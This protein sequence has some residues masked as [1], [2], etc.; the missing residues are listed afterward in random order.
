[1][2]F[3]V[4]YKVAEQCKRVSQFVNVFPTQMKRCW[5]MGTL[6]YCSVSMF[7]HMNFGPI[8]ICSVW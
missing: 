8:H 2:Q 1:M 6:C 5:L 7:C 3:M 4:Q